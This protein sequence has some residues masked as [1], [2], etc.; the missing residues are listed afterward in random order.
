MQ[1]TAF[2]VIYIPSSPPYSQL[3]HLQQLVIKSS[4]IPTPSVGST[5]V[6]FQGSERLLF[7][8]YS[9]L[10]SEHPELLL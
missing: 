7:E 6:I 4:G 5:I 2:K 1:L 10:Q 8:Y 9:H 3:R